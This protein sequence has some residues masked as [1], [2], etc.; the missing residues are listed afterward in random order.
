V[1]GL[2]L[3]HKNIAVTFSNSKKL[4]I[5]QRC[6]LSGILDFRLRIVGLEKICPQ[7]KIGK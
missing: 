5:S 7:I 2:S 1:F 6:F 3:M 4:S